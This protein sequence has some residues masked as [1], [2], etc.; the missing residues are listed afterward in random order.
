MAH[1]SVRTFIC[2][3]AALAIVVAAP[4][5]ASAAPGAVDPTFGILF[6]GTVI[7]ADRGPA[8][9]VVKVLRQTD[10]KIVTVA[11]AVDADLTSSLVVSRF[12]ANGQIDSTFV[13]RRPLH[14]PLPHRRIRD[15]RRVAAGRQDRRRRFEQQSRRLLRHPPA[16]RTARS[17]RPWRSPTCRRTSVVA[18]VDEAF[19]V[20][21]APG[22]KIVVAG[23]AGREHRARAL[24]DDR[25][26][27][28]DLRRQRP[29]QARL[30]RTV[31]SGRRRGARRPAHRRQRAARA[32]RAAR[33]AS[34]WHG[35][36]R[37]ARSTRRSA[38]PAASIRRA[39]PRRFRR[40]HCSC[41]E[42]SC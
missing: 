40:P 21:I 7:L 41:K 24:H 5:V 22:G 36:P 34:C 31:R 2:G 6:N 35:S 14:P 37:T 1:S 16:R 39:P 30:R 20:A 13:R 38:R 26:A 10:G 8:D 42:P 33:R 3:M 29:P 28:R 17:I 18:T 15:R 32:R 23:R 27:R 9:F 25:R 12:L 19:A 4:A 11:S